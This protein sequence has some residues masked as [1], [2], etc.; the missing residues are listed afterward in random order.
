MKQVSRTTKR[1]NFNIL[2]PRKSINI[3]MFKKRHVIN[4]GEH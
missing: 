4:K 2:K 1:A 3:F